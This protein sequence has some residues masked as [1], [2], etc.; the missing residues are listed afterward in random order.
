MYG[1]AKMITLPDG[2]HMQSPKVVVKNRGKN[3][4]FNDSTKSAC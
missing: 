1:L 2:K 3:D 4:K